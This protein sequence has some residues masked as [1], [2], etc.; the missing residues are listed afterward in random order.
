MSPALRKPK[1]EQNGFLSH[2]GILNYS[3]QPLK[4]VS[5][6]FPLK[7][8]ASAL[9]FHNVLRAASATLCRSP[10]LPYSF[11]FLV[12]EISDVPVLCPCVSKPGS[13]SGERTTR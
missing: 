4:H 13:I 2:A 8:W 11:L 6:S 12:I 7:V 1:G 10:Y 9:T 5:L 3:C